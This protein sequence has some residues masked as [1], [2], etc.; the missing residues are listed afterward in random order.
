VRGNAAFH[1]RRLLGR[2]EAVGAKLGQPAV[3]SA[4][5]YAL[6]ASKV[7][8]TS[9]AEAFLL[10][11]FP[12]PTVERREARRQNRNSSPGTVRERERI[13]CCHDLAALL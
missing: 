13:E 8:S 4:L 2:D 1:A 3:N 10:G 9:P 5:R 11:E 7:A 6:L 12:D